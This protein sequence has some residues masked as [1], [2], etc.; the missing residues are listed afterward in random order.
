MPRQK[1]QAA[2]REGLEVLQSCYVAISKLELRSDK[3][4]NVAIPLAYSSLEQGRSACYLVANQPDHCYFAAIILFRSQ[5]EQLIRAQFFAQPASED[6]LQHFLDTDTLPDQPDG[7][8]LGPKSLARINTAHFGWNSDKLTDMVAENWKHLSAF[9][10]GG[11]AVLNFYRSKDGIGPAELT[12]EFVEPV[13][14]IVVLGH[15]TVALAITLAE[16]HTSDDVQAHLKQWFD[17]GHAYFAKWAP[18]AEG[19]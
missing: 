18:K 16:N 17:K 10:H 14:N 2:A 12:N 8:K 11:R 15:L 9:A 5:L 3:R 13:T 6:Q 19:P 4:V 7:Q 1:L